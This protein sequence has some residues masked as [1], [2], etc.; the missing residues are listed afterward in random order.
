[1]AAKVL[2]RHCWD[3]VG[4]M[5]LMDGLWQQCSALLPSPGWSLAKSGR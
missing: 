1:M 2:L 5:A 3:L 4:E